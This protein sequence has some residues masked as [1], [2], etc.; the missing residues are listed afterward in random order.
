VDEEGIGYGED[1]GE[2]VL[3]WARRKAEAVAPLCPGR[4]VLGAD[5]L[6]SV[7][8]EILGKPMS[9]SNAREMLQILSGRVHSVF[10]GVCVL[11]L[12][13]D[14]DLELVEET[15]VHFRSLSS[16]EIDAYIETGEPMD[17]A[18]AYGIQDYGSLL[19][20]R[21]EGCYFNV[22][23]LPVSRVLEAIRVVGS[24]KD[25]SRSSPYNHE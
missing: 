5:T 20:R 19:V 1:P 4:P 13:R 14:I 11:W 25:A 15:R 22:M 21:V 8:G 17:K 24:A 9:A 18:G 23:G 6:V 3:K 16:R 10:G 12:A 7:D 2:E